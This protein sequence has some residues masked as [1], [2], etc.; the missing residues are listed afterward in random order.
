MSDGIPYFNRNTIYSF[1]DSISK[2]AGTHSLKAGVYYEH[3]GKIQSAS[4]LTRGS[5]SFNQDGNNAL[6]TNE[7]Y[8]T[9]LLGNYDSYAESTGRPQGHFEFINLEGFVQDTWR[10]RPNLSLDFGVRFYH[11]P[12]QYDA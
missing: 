7:P 1:T 11:D 4:T 12:P 6:D 2:I 9:A 10:V 5:V 3:T 8:G